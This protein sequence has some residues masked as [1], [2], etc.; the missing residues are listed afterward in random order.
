[1]RKDTVQGCDS[2]D[3]AGVLLEHSPPC[4]GLCPPPSSEACSN[5][6][7]ILCLSLCPG[8][9][10]AGY[11]QCHISVP[12]PR[13]SAPLRPA[14]ALFPPQTPYLHFLFSLLPYP[15][16]CYFISD[17]CLWLHQENKLLTMLHGLSGSVVSPSSPLLPPP[18]QPQIHLSEFPKLMDPPAP[19]PWRT[20]G[21]TPS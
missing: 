1:M 11:N 6:W 9:F 13:R 2:G 16:F 17:H 10:P 19:G 21:V 14:H 15:R 7:S 12:V 4:A 20:R 3:R 18:P 8:S 5:A